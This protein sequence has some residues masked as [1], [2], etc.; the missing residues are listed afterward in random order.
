MEKSYIYIRRHLSYDKYNACKLGKSDNIPMR[1]STYITGEIERGFFEHVIEVPK[2]QSNI[3]E[4]ML[5]NYFI[6][7]RFRIYKN[8]GT[9]FFKQDIIPLILPYL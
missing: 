6:I 2:D 3:I 8:G 9:E 7:L 4:K 5:Q 1:D